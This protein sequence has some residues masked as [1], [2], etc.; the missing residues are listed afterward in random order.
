MKHFICLFVLISTLSSFSDNSIVVIEEVLIP[1]SGVGEY[2]EHAVTRFG[3]SGDDRIY[4]VIKV[5]DGLVIV[6]QTNSVD[7]DFEGVN[8]GDFRYNDS[9]AFR[10]EEHTSELQSRGHLVC[11][12]LLE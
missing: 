5:D 12:L 11:R 2:V 6:G 3:G 8:V 4:D 7:G 1:Y 9:S 10:S